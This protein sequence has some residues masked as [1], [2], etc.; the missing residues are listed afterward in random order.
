MSVSLG[1]KALFCDERL[2]RGELGI[3]ASGRFGSILYCVH[4][5]LYSSRSLA[6]ELYVEQCSIRWREELVWV[7]MGSMLREE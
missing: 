7:G 6:K 1:W 4:D 3:L 5:E 2:T